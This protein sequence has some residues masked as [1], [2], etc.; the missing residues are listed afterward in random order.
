LN[1]RPHSS[2]GDRANTKG[3]QAAFD[4]DRFAPERFVAADLRAVRRVAVAPRLAVAAVCL[5]D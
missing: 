4:R 3:G 1:G 2:E 5:A